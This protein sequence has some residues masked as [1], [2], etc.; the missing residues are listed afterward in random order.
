MDDSVAEKKRRKNERKRQRY[1]EDREFRERVNAVNRTHWLENKDAINVRRRGKYAANPKRRADSRKS[2]LKWKYGM[3]VEQYAAKLAD[4]G[5][6]CIICLKPKEKR[7]CVDHNH[8][9]RKLRSLL[10]DKCNLGLGYFDED[11]AAL[12]RGGDYVDYWQWR[13]ANPDDTGPPPFALSSLHR[14]FAPSLPSIQSPPLTGE[15]MTP[16]DA[17]TEDSKASR[18]MR[19][20]ILHELHQPFDP[21]EPPPAYKL[22]AVARAVVNKAAQGDLAAAKEILDRIGGWSAPPLSVDPGC[23]DRTPAHARPRR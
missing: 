5:G 11:S 23:D 18:L 3:S 22:Q 21:A 17:T 15:G 4:Q 1:A 13:H 10:C 14:L 19:R 8:E 7:L 16:T 6:V 20:A 9:T 12:R 2:N